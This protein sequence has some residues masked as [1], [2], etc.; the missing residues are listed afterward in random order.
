MSGIGGKKRENFENGKKIGLFEGK[1]V[2]INPTV[3]E[4]NEVLGIPVEEDKS[5]EYLSEKDGTTMLRLE[6]WLEEIKSKQ[7][8]KV[9][10]FLKDS[11]RTNRE[12]TK[13]QYINELGSC[14]W[15]DD[16]T[17]LADWFTKRDYREAK[18]G[19]EAMYKFLR[20]WL[21]NLDYR[22]ASTTLNIDWKKLMKG[23]VS[24]LK[25]QLGGELTTNVGCLATVRNVDKDGETKQY[26]GVYDRDFLPAYALKNFRLV[27][28]TKPETIKAIAAKLPKDRKFHEKFVMAVV[29]PEHGCKDSYTLKSLRDYDPGEDFVASSEVL[30]EEGSDY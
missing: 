14:T 26:Q 11:V 25:A 2:A 17:N 13:T 5:I 1:V 8:M 3:E 29:D 24:E 30:T 15:A 9:T 20:T 21:G 7:K 16:E 6:F 23:N 18:T 22:D 19:E 10:F 27:D 12:G 28:Y 4:F